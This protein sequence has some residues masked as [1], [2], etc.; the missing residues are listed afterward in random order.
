MASRRNP[1]RTDATRSVVK[2][3]KSGAPD[4]YPDVDIY[5]STLTHISEEHADAYAHLESIYE[6]IENPPL[7]Y[8]SRT[9]KRSVLVVNKQ[10][11]NKHGE[12]L[13]IPIKVVS[14]TE[15]IMSTALFAS[16][17][18]YDGELLWKPK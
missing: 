18:H 3:V 9:N 17:N 7:I 10:I 13:R 1:N 5:D 4:I 8:K 12:P 16:S 14:S 11:V 2:K 15:A 6:S